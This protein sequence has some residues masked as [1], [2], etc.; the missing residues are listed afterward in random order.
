MN[1]NTILIV[2]DEAV[3][4]ADLAAKLKRIGY[5]VA[6]IARKGEEAVAMAGD[7]RPRLILMDIQLKGSVDGIQ[8]AELI[9]D[10]HDVPV[11]YLTAHSDAAT[12]NRAKITGPFGYILKPFEERALATQIE[13]ALYKHQADREIREQREWLRVTLT[14]IGDAVIATDARGSVTFINPVAE[15]LTG[16]KTEDAFGHPLLSVFHIINEQTGQPLDDPVVR[17]LC[18]GRAVAL[19]NHAAIVTKDGRTVPIEDSAAPILNA[20]G[21]VIGAVLVFHDVAEKRRSEE[22]LRQSSQ[23][24]EENP[25]PVMRCTIDGDLMYANVPA[26]HWLVSLGWK[27]G[28]PLPEPVLMV[29][30]KARGRDD[31]TETEIVTLESLTFSL[32]AVQ[33]PGEEY[34]NLYGI[35]ITGRKQAEDELHKAKDNLEVRVRKRTAELKKRAEQLAR[36]SSKLTLA[37]QRERSR[38]AKILHDHLQQLLVGAKINS[39]VLFSRIDTDHKKLA[40]NIVDLISQSIQVSRSLT[41]EVSPPVLQQGLSPTLEWTCRRMQKTHGLTVELKADPL[42]GSQSEDITIFLYQSARELLLNVVKHAGVKSAR[43]EMSSEGPDRLRLTVSDEG[44]GF[45]PAA[46][47]MTDASG[48]GLL[49]IRERAELMGGKLQIMS[50]PGKGASV[51]LFVPLEAKEERVEQEIRKTM[52]R[53]HTA[54]GAGEKIRVLLVDDHTVV[55]QGLST[56]LNFH[57]DI[58]VVGEAADG[59]EAVEKAR[60]FQPDVILMD[61]SMPKMDGIEATRIIGSELPHIRIVGLSMHDKQDQANRMI[62]AG[63]SAY[64]TKDGD[65]SVLLSEIRRIK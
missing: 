18:E 20:G 53:V 50:S 60:E 29:L 48:F 24:P 19:A 26:Q 42:N 56:M 3:V 2:E 52:T 63:A 33:P 10:Q 4:A 45:D 11:I 54:D 59:E 36:M 61:I 7:L 51:S 40:E 13:L 16:W 27:A 28:D 31:F 12:L 9:A 49:S 15:S 55:R 35:D 34:I 38:I 65:T 58:Q 14:S 46:I 37:E 44:S 5:E 21:Q 62:E 47:W 17:V 22:A 25:N 1:K 43:L 57:S 8:A 39:E 30:T 41:L 23:F 6:G 32:F 64:C